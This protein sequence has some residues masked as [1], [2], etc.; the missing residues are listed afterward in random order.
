MTYI[1]DSIIEEAPTAKSQ[2]A[3]RV[4]AKFDVVGFDDPDALVGMSSFLTH[5]GIL[6][7]HNFD[8]ILWLATLNP[9]LQ[10]LLRKT[11]KVRLINAEK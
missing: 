4:L 5:H 2:Q 10:I 9:N 7:N 11:R 1:P 3:L 6:H 8:R